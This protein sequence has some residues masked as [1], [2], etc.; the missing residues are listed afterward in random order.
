MTWLLFIAA[1]LAVYAVSLMVS[2]LTGP[3]G[4]FSKLRRSAKGSLK[5][6]IS[7]PICAGV[8]VAGAVAAFLAFRGYL[9][10]V[11]LPLWVLAIAGANALVHQ[12]DEH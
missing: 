5:E 2:K 4:I 12:A 1:T 10:W 3:G 11:E 8:W 6:G 9:P 7:C